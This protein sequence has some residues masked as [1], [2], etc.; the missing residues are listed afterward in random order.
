M[1][2]KVIRWKCILILLLLILFNCK[3]EAPNIFEWKTLEVTAT[4]YNSLVSQTNNN[5]YIT[6]FGDSLKPG[7]R[8]IA[9][10]RDLLR[11]GLKHNTLVKVDG[12]EGTYLVKDKMHSRWTNKI[13]IYMGTDVNAAKEWG[14]SK[15]NI[16]YRVEKLKH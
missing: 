14:R 3:N 8:Y 12:L 16:S 10:S 9:V 6:A 2:F 11:L 15:V 1:I 5:P 13:D 7:V 4:A